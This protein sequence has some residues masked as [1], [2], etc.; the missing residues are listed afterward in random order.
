MP[1]V[2]LK[3]KK[4]WLSVFLILFAL[5]LFF[6]AS[7]LAQ[8]DINADIQAQLLAGSNKAGFDTANTAS[9]Q[10]LIA[11]IIKI[12]LSLLGTIFVV[13][14]VMSGFWYLTARGEE[15]KVQ[16]ATKTIR[17]AVIGLF[18]VICAYAITAFVAGGVQGALGKDPAVDRSP[19]FRDGRWFR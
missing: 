9:P 12:F 16:K 17:G 15:E 14:M 19:G 3:N 18:L 13:L 11:S 1:T 7:A 4:R 8:T 2:S 5:T 6:T 10:S